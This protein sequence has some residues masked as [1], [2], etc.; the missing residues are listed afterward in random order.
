MITIPLNDLPTAVQRQLQSLKL[1]ETASIVQGS[2]QVAEI[3]LT[4][5]PEFPS[6]LTMNFHQPGSNPLGLPI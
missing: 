6:E 2:A 1:G 5:S 4:V 3:T